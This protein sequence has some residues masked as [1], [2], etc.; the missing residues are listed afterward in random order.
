M[1][2]YLTRRVSFAAAHRYRIADWSDERNEQ[3][4]GLCARPSFHGHS[5]VCDVT[6]SGEIDATTGFIVDLGEL[7]R[8]LAAEVRH[9]FDHRNINV[10]VAEFTDGK[11]MPTGENLARFIFQRVQ[12][13]LATRGSAAR[14]TSVTVA[15][16][17]TLSATYRED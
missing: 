2:A 12:R 17:A 9:R 3:V 4:F 6:V 13:A 14:V 16:D 10:D 1:P 7:D 8:I 11:L 15:E 5:Y